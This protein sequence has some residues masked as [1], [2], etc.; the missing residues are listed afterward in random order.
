MKS[1]NN[2]KTL[3]MQSNIVAILW[4]LM[5]LAS[6]CGAADVRPG[7]AWLDTDGN[8]IES[9]L[10]GILYENGTYYWYG[11]NFRGKTMAPQTLPGQ[12][13]SWMAN[14]GVS[15]YSSNDLHR[16]K[17]ERMTLQQSTSIPAN[18]LL[19]R[20]KAIKNDK[21]GKYVL[22]AQMCAHD[23]SHNDILV[24]TSDSPTGP[25]KVDHV[26]TPPGGAYDITLYKDLDGKAY[27][28]TSHEWVKVHELN[29]DY[30][31]IKKTVQVEGVLG[32]AP[33]V[34]R[35]D[36]VYYLLTSHLTGWAPNPNKYSVASS[37]WGPW[38][39]K[40]TFCTGPGSENTFA[41]QTTHVLPLA[42]RKGRFIFMAD[43]TNAKTAALIDD[44]GKMTHVWL[45][46]SLDPVAKT[47][48]VPWRDQW[49]LGV[50]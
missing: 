32:E 13:F 30:L 15:I 34:F 35:Y 41:A 22:M 36:G 12:T 28:I 11:M 39:P 1:K 38:Q 37:I 23:W 25:F 10:G 46:I 27:L 9:H 48:R 17:L 14:Q 24:A 7:Q 2:R 29:D 5:C 44:L 20:P 43:R 31:S 42:D 8:P 18:D 6:T 16:W 50:F 49:N 26:F 3:A 21:T 19:L 45:P 4:E 47:I 40:G 33:A